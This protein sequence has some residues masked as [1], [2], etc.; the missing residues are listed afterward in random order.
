M[1]RAERLLA[2]MRASKADWSS[3]EVIAVYRWAGFDVLHGSKHDRVQHPE[4]PWLIGT[5][6]RANP[7]PTGYIETLLELLDDLEVLR[8]GKSQ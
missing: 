3:D 7:L 5:V 8:K 2:R 6:R 1:S 4:F